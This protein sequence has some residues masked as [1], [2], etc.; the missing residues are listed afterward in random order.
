MDT[1]D[2]YL[3]KSNTKYKTL[4]TPEGKTQKSRLQRTQST[5]AD[6]HTSSQDTFIQSFRT[7]QKVAI[8]ATRLDRLINIRKAID[9]QH[10][11]SQRTAELL[12]VAKMREDMKLQ[13]LNEG[14]DKVTESQFHEAKQK[15]FIRDFLK[16]KE[17]RIASGLA[18]DFYKSRENFI[19][20]KSECLLV[21]NIRNNIITKFKNK[22]EK[23]KLLTQHNS[24][25]FNSQLYL[26]LLKRK[27]QK[28]KDDRVLVEEANS[29]KDI[30]DLKIEDVYRRMYGNGSRLVD[31]DPYD[32]HDYL[33]YKYDR[34]EKVGFASNRIKNVISSID[35]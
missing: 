3:S 8:S 19:N 14:I 34:Y 10:K 5:G 16:M 25:D 13:D 1:T 33:L 24:I 20:F 35:M 18:D 12:K 27:C 30:V 15:S 29:K 26:N 28:A 23:L 7:P 4:K 31:I 6:T 11:K 17:N 21:P 32:Y 2:K 22:E 9:D